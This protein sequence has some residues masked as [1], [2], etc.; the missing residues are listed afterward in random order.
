M[1]SHINT[2]S[3]LT[4]KHSISKKLISEKEFSVAEIAKLSRE[5]YNHYEQSLLK[6]AEIKGVIDT[7]FGDGEKKR[8]TE[9]LINGYNEGFTFEQLS[10]I[11]KLPVIEIEKIILASK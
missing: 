9:I 2:H 11:T 5:D 4:Q 7:A 6:Y 8:T 3:E 10:R 1:E